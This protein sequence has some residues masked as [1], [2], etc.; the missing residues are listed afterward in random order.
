MCLS[1][2]LN[3][4][5]ALFLSLLITDG[6]YTLLLL[7]V[8]LIP[9]NVLYYKLQNRFN[10]GLIYVALYLLLIFAVLFAAFII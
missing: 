1:W 5:L 6:G 7:L 8:G 4:F 2:V 10:S 3:Q 9:L